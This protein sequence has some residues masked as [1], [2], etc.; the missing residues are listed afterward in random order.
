MNLLLR[1][2]PE[3][4]AF[5]TAL[6]RALLQAVGDGR[7]GESLRLHEPG[8]VVAFSILD[9]TAPGFR[10][11][12]RAAGAQGFGA[13]IRLAGGR[14]AVFHRRTL[15]FAWCSAA[16]DPRVGIRERFQDTAEIFAEALRT[17]GVDA[18][19]GA[20]PGEYCPGEYSVNAGGRRKL[21]GVGQ[22]VVQGAAHVGG[23]LV[24]DA[25]DRV[26]DV[27][28]PVYEA[29]G[30][31]FDPETVGSL[32]DELGPVSHAEVVE[33]LVV[34]FSRRRALVDAELGADL[35]E[36]ASKLEVEHQVPTPLQ[37]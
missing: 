30:L 27:L 4:P 18:R 36:R 31:S 34:A 8:D 10:A 14:A 2:F 6:S 17:L 37:A 32:A 5:D 12:V 20:V 23:V 3:R 28:V 13:I 22:R 24:L 16:R 1:S 19:I 21:M 7:A 25:A 26:R 11:A 29:L 9:R 33:A 35:L 15:S